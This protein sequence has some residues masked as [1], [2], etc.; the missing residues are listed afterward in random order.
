MLYVWN[1]NGEDPNDVEMVAFDWRP[2]HDEIVRVREDGSQVE[3]LA[4]HHSY[5]I[6]YGDTPR[7]SVSY[8]G[9]YVV[10]NSNWAGSGRTDVYAVEVAGTSATRSP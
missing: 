1:P 6:S 5:Y 7:A 9:K 10:F 2:I 3:R 8:D 4:H